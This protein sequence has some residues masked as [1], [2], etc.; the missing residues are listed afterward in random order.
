MNLNMKSGQKIYQNLP[1]TRCKNGLK[2]LNVSGQFE[3]AASNYKSKLKL[4]IEKEN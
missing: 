4:N 2:R 3:K 1:K